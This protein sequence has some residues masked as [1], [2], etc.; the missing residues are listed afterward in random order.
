MVSFSAAHARAPKNA[1]GKKA[2]DMTLALVYAMDAASRLAD[3]GPG[4]GRCVSVVDARGV[5]LAHLD[6]SAA[7]AV[8]AVAQNHYPE[9]S[10]A[11]YVYGAPK[12][13]AALVTLL[14]PLLAPA[15]RGKVVFVAANGGAPAA[16]AWAHVPG[17]D[18][19]SLPAEIGGGAG[20]AEPVQAAARRAGVVAAGGAPAVSAPYGTVA[21]KSDT[22]PPSGKA[23]KAGPVAIAA[24]AQ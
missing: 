5:G 6:A 19:A 11:T 16:A 12:T 7:R 8:V 13:F 9:R 20:P 15:S 4:D 2:A 17:V 23:S 18:A 10:L 21:G 24:T 1:V 14:L 22:A 3:A